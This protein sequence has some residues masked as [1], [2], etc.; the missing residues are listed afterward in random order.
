[1][2]RPPLAQDRLERRADG[3]ILVELRK[4]WRDGTTHLLLE[5]FELLEKLAALT[6]RP[7]AHLL[8][9]HGVLAPHAAW[10]QRVVGFARPP[11]DAAAEMLFNQPAAAGQPR[12]QAWAVLMHR[13][14]GLD[15]LG[16][17]RCGSRLRPLATISDLAIVEQI[18][19]HLGLIPVHRSPGPAPPPGPAIIAQP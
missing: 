1:V 13:A 10:R 18:L 2:L 17:P 7:A 4:A 5:P 12:Y 9:Y 11:G 19:A 6:P 16:C 15:V 14:F 8:L 3:R